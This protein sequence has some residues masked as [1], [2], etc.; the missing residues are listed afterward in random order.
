MHGE[1]PTRWPDSVDLVIFRT[2]PNAEEV[3]YVWMTQEQKF[4]LFMMLTPAGKDWNQI[5]E[6]VLAADLAHANDL[7]D[8][9]SRRRV[10][11]R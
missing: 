5:K 7:L 4:S 3:P 2:Q 10:L 6:L 8:N 1:K 11:V 9:S